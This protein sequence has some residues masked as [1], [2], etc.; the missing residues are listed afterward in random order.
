MAYRPYDVDDD[1]FAYV[2]EPSPVVQPVGSSVAAT[3]QSLDDDE[4]DDFCAFMPS[5]NGAPI[6]TQIAVPSY[7]QFVMAPPSSAAAAIAGGSAALTDSDEVQALMLDISS[8]QRHIDMLSARVTVLEQA[9]RQKDAEH[10]E[11]LRTYMQ[12]ALENQQRLE[13]VERETVRAESL[14]LQKVDDT[15]KAAADAEA[16]AIQAAAEAELAA[17]AVPAEP[18]S[19]DDDDE[20]DVSSRSS[21][22]S[23]GTTI[24]KPILIAAR[25]F[26]SLSAAERKKM[27]VV[28]AKEFASRLAIEYKGTK[29]TMLDALA[30][31]AASVLASS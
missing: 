21:S 25:E 23:A 3:T 8:K 19:L 24:P 31:A 28:T 26:Q 29:P 22:S 9:L 30:A 15:T 13:L 14:L 1:D 7:S 11:E 2:G 18:L 12:A 10:V 4:D 16:A 27:S 20:A 17:A 5:A 6:A